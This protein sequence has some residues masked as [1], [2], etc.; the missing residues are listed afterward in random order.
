VNKNMC[1]ESVINRPNLELFLYM[2]LGLEV[3]LFIDGRSLMCIIN[4]E[5][6]NDFFYSFLCLFE[7]KFEWLILDWSTD[8][9]V[10]G[11]S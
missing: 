7:L 9:M 10:H 1:L 11:L 5:I 6:Q 2:M 8:F 4:I 3:I